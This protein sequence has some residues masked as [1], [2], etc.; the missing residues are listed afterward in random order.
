MSKFFLGVI[1]TLAV[2]YPQVTKHKL[3]KLI[4]SSHAI[5]MHTISEVAR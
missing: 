4:D 3:N 2:L 5:L 1:V